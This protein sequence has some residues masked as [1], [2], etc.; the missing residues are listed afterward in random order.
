MITESIQNIWRT[1]PYYD[2]KVTYTTEINPK[3]LEREVAIVEYRVYN[4]K[5][6]I[7]STPETRLD[8]RA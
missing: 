8:L 6:Q 3:T 7:E 1:N 2:S 5:G 4:S